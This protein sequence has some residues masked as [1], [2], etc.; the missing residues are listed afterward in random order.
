MPPVSDAQR[1]AMY[2]AS[3]GKSTLGIPKSVGQEFVG[4]ASGVEGLTG[5]PKKKPIRRGRH[6]GKP[7]AT[8]ESA[9]AE[10]TE[11]M[12]GQDHAKKK[13]AAFA[14]MRALHASAPQPPKAPTPSSQQQGQ[15]PTG[16]KIAGLGQPSGVLA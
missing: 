4:G 6:A 2:A 7:K 12:G 9:H 15:Q 3:E 13:S 8:P 11:A 16:Q 14:L 5:L 1:K 10:L